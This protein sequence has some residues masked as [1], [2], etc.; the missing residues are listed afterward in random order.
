MPFLSSLLELIKPGGYL[1]W[2]ERDFQTNRILVED[3]AKSAA[4]VAPKLHAYMENLTGSLL[5]QT[6]WIESFHTRF[7]DAGAELVAH[8][9]HWV[10]KEALLIKQ[11]TDFLSARELIDNQRAG[12][13]GS[14]EAA[15]FEKL[16]EESQEECRRL[17]RGTVVDTEMVTWVARKK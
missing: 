5:A 14:L 15:E 9:R 16:L 8:D 17:Q 10:A 2:Q 12:D 6:K 13:P 3:K 4:E 1:Q 11:E 7:D